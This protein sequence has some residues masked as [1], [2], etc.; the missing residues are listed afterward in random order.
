MISSSPS[1]ASPRPGPLAAPAISAATTSGTRPPG[2][3]AVILSTRAGYATSLEPS[4]STQAAAVGAVRKITSPGLV[5]FTAST[6]GTLSAPIAITGLQAGEE[7]HGIDFRPASGH[8]FALGSTNRL[9]I[10]SLTTGVA[11]QVGRDHVEVTGERFEL[12]PPVQA[13]AGAPAVQQ[14]DG[15][16][17]ARAL[18]LADERRPAAG[19]VEAAPVGERRPCDAQRR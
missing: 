17:V 2:S 18:D 16:R 4:T 9:Y 7:I 14:Q 10:L 8:L 1:I 11:T 6:P 12:V 15:G 13:G 3:A 5:S 19:Q